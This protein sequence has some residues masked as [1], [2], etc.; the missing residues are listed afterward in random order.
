MLRSSSVNSASYYSDYGSSTANNT[1]SNT[2]NNTARGY[3][4]K[5]VSALDAAKS[6]ALRTLKMLNKSSVAALQLDEVPSEL[7]F[8][9][10]VDLHRWTMVLKDRNLE[11][12]SKQQY[13]GKQYFLDTSASKV[14]DMFNTFYE[15]TRIKDG[16]LHLNISNAKDI[17]NYGITMIARNNPNLLSI[18]ISGCSNITDIALREIGMNCS[19]LENL[20]ISSC[21]EIDGSGLG[22]IAE[23]CRLLLKLNISKCRTIQNWSMKKIF[24]ECKQL[25]EVNVSY[26]N[27]IGDEEIRVLAQNCCHLLTLS[28]AECPYISDTSIQIVAQ[29]CLDIDYIDL[30]RNEMQYRISD[31]SMLALGQKSHSLRTLKLNGCDCI[32]D[33]G[34]NWLTEGCKALEEID[35]SNCNKVS[36]ELYCSNIIY[37]VYKLP[38][39]SRI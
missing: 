28:A 19:K 34:L 30:S 23:T 35:L 5:P 20:N 37:V 36:T 16:L 33:V 7:L 14:G 11:E 8:G 24:Y 2:A 18:D 29:H 21:L 31:I 17:T 12:L 38:S 6:I 32:T 15:A 26:L 1:A 9:E 25:E 13:S 22:A 3:E 10:T 4:R 27:K 39:L